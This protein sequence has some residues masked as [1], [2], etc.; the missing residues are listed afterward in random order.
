MDKETFNIYAWLIVGVL[1]I[2]AVISQITIFGDT[3]EKGLYDMADSYIEKAEAV[4]LPAMGTPLNDCSWAQIQ[5]ICNENLE[6]DYF[7]V[8]DEKEIILSYLNGNTEKITVVIL[9]FNKDYVSNSKKTAS[10]TF[11]FKDC[12]NQKT[13]MNNTAS[14][15][16]G[17][18]NADVFSAINDE[19]NYK[20]IYN[21]MPE[22]LKNL[23]VKVNKAASAGGLSPILQK[24]TVKL[25]ILSEEEI[26][27]K[28]MG[29]GGESSTYSFYKFNSLIKKSNNVVTDY[30]LRSPV[31][32]DAG[33]YCY[34]TEGGIVG[35]AEA[36]A[37]KG[38]SLA[39]C[40]K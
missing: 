32:S 8:G 5:K 3:T 4:E 15:Q 11:G 7:N 16:D 30:W 26:G 9:D 38:L 39:F 40:L 18:T 10:I 20:S 23:I 27:T 1:I 12:L 19:E 36:N 25:F 28:Q 14:N 24:N 2:M 33:K 34:V 6:T 31:A 35:A 17:W 21:A 22:Q 37:E 13:P 29:I